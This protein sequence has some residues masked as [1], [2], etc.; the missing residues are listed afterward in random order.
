MASPDNKILLAFLVALTDLED[1]LS[2]QERHTLNNLAGQLYHDRQNW[3]RYEPNLLKLINSNKVLAQLYQ[4]AKSHIDAVDWDT[5]RDLLPTPE[6]LKQAIPTD[7]QSTRGNQPT[8]T[9]LDRSDEIANEV[10][11]YVSEDENPPGAVKKLSFIQ[12]IKQKI[13]RF[14]QN[15]N[16]NF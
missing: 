6:E 11:I 1:P 16:N 5:L 2:D 10:F 8:R 9:D 3:E 13:Q 7:K 4:V 12:E 14:L 15:R